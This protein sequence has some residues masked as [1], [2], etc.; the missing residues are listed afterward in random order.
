MKKPIQAHFQ[1]VADFL[2]TIHHN[3]TSSVITTSHTS[4][5][6]L[7]GTNMKPDVAICSHNAIRI[8]IFDYF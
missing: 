6:S 1:C 2:S 7:K 4:I 8:I 3:S 5:I